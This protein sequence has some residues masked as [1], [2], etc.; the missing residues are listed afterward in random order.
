[1][2]NLY[3]IKQASVVKVILLGDE[4]KF[5]KGPD[6]KRLLRV[7]SI[8]NSVIITVSVQGE[9]YG[10]EVLRSPLTKIQTHRHT[11]AQRHTQRHSRKDP[12]N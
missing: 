7:P 11:E 4:V 10:R 5:V 9:C 1:M 2:F 12:S 8:I 3:Y 6:I